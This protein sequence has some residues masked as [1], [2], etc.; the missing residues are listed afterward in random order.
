MY[1]EFS[2][3]PPSERIV[4]I[5]PHVPKL[6]SN[7]KQRTFLEHGYCSTEHVFF[8]VDCV[9]Y[10]VCYHCNGVGK[11]L[12]IMSQ[13]FQNIWQWLKDRAI[14]INAPC[15]NSTLQWDGAVGRDLWCM[16][17]FRNVSRS[18]KNNS[19]NKKLIFYKKLSSCH[20]NDSDFS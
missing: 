2:C 9:C 12:Q 1:R 15:D 10:I 8:S 7:I 17:T 18:K 16:A 13:N 4:K 19:L 14:K 11:Q 6:L 5:G 20:F 3:K